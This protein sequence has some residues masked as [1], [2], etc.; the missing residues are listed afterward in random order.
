MPLDQRLIESLPAGAESGVTL[1]AIREV[2][3]NETVFVL[4]D[5]PTGTQTVRDALILTDWDDATLHDVIEQERL[6]FLLT[7]SRSLPAP[8]AVRIARRT[9]AAIHRLRRTVDR[10]IVLISRSDSTL[11]GHFPIEVDALI[12]SAVM[13]DARIILAPFFGPGD[14]ITIDDTHY[15]KRDGAYVPVGDTEYARDAVFGYQSS[16]L[17]DWIKETAGSDRSVASVSVRA[18]RVDGPTAVVRALLDLPPRGIC[19]C[20]L[21]TSDA[22]DE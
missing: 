16:N 9:G 12:E 18:L 22:A 3:T 19:I 6:V 14:R 21:Y 10:S 2:A 20:L 13:P 11:R 7:N 1:A 15:I 4:D 8:D 17:R 5:D